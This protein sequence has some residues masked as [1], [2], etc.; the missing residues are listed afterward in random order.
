MVLFL[1]SCATYAPPAT[2]RPMGSHDAPWVI[3]GEKE[4]LDIII[5]INGE[6]V[7]HGSIPLFSM[8]DTASFHGV[9]KGNHVAVSCFSSRGA[10]SSNYRCQVVV[11]SELAANLVF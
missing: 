2:Y 9:Y 11:G 7:A 4:S 8:S 1:A 5:K 10:F 3:T 6:R